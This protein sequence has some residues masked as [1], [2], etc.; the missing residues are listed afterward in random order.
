MSAEHQIEQEI[1][2]ELSRN[3]TSTEVFLKVSSKETIDTHD[4]IMV[5]ESYIMDLIRASQYNKEE[6]ELH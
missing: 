6:N 4:L 3:E 5:L 1:S 2:I